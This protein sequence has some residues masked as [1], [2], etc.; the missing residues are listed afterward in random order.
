MRGDATALR[1][2][3]RL[4]RAAEREPERVVAL[5]GRPLRRFDSHSGRPV[6]TKYGGS[7]FVE[8]AICDMC[9]GSTEFAL[10]GLMPQSAGR[11]R[12][13]ARRHFLRSTAM[14]LPY[15]AEAAV[16]SKRLEV[17]QRIAAEVAP[18]QRG[19][20][21][22]QTN[23]AAT[24]GE[25]ILPL[26]PRGG[27]AVAPG[28]FLLTH[29]LSCLFQAVFDQAVLL[30][31]EIDE[32]A[33][34]VTGVVLNKP[35][36]VTLG[37]IV[38]RWPDAIDKEWI[39]SQNLGALLESKIYRGGPVIDESL[40]D[41]LRWVHRHAVPGAR[42]IAPGLLV[43][44]ELSAIAK[45]SGGDSAGVRFVLGYAAWTPL[46]L[47]IE[48]ESGVWVRARAAGPPSPGADGVLGLAF[49]PQERAD[50]WRAGMR[51]IGLRAFAEFPRTPAVDRRLRSYLERVHREVDAA[52]ANG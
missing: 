31:D 47:R 37:R 11:I 41:S 28:D 29:P 26:P 32:A 43:G 38:E 42:E 21:D 6:S 23:V 44:G 49:D 15:A 18:P 50:A 1:R 7:P 14:G 17:A 8:D 5:L 30:L 27:P 19:V 34:R 35:T 48:L 46:Q 3:L 24:S 45:A 40:S 4:C 25:A 39:E 13:A 10:P 12:G 20:A 2:L 33:H 9:G 52:E 16:L 51:S 36:G 22:A